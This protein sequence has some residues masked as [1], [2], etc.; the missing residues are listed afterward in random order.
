M[1]DETISEDKRLG[2]NTPRRSEETIINHIHEIE[3]DSD[4]EQNQRIFDECNIPGS[5][6]AKKWGDVKQDLF[7]GD[8][9][10]N[11]LSAVMLTA[12]RGDIKEFADV[13]EVWWAHHKVH[14]YQYLGE[15]L[16]IKV[17]NALRN[18]W[19]DEKR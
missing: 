7:E 5:E 2:I 4:R 14:M 19:E 10:R 16:Y 3:T 9:K 11:N 8:R 12:E 6:K 17:L 18:K 15:D 13:Y 1:P